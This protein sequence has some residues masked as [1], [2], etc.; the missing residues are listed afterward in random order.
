M[1]L[2]TNNKSGLSTLLPVRAIHST[3]SQGYPLYS[4]SGLSAL[5]STSQGGGGSGIICEI[6]DMGSIDCSSLV[7][8]PIDFLSAPPLMPFRLSKSLADRS[9]ISE[10]SVTAAAGFFLFAIVESLPPLAPPALRIDDNRSE[11]PSCRDL[12]LVE[13]FLVVFLPVE[14]AVEAVMGSA[15]GVGA[16][17]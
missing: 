3:P 11:R 16:A 5:G 7:T 2:V 17:A 12:H 8:A 4:Q 15:V 14:A 13:D 1:Y 6:L 10:G 9:S